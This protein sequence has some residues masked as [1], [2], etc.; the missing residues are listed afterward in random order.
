M[1]N[2]VQRKD[3]SLPVPCPVGLNFQLGELVFMANW[4]VALWSC[5]LEMERLNSIVL[6]SETFL[7]TIAK[8]YILSTEK[9]IFYILYEFMHLCS[10]DL[11]CKA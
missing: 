1:Q 8:A 7:F 9:L 3:Q 2:S 11:L 5:S 4:I 6:F 10:R